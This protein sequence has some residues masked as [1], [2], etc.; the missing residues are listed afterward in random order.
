MII[1]LPSD[2]RLK[3]TD[4]AFRSF[5][6]L[7][8]IQFKDQIVLKYESQQITVSHSQMLRHCEPSGMTHVSE[9]LLTLKLLIIISFWFNLLFIYYHIIFMSHIWIIFC[10]SSAWKWRHR[11]VKICSR[12]GAVAINWTFVGFTAN[13]AQADFFKLVAN[14]FIQCWS[15]SQPTQINTLSHKLVEFQNHVG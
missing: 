4:E 2:I 3:L 12:W 9:S 8:Q 13:S 10:E 1:S 15:T 6:T 11:S 7:S 14:R 5:L